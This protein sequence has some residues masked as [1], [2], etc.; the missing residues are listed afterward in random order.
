[1]FENLDRNSP[2][3]YWLLDY[4]EERIQDD[5]QWN[6]AWEIKKFGENIFKEEYIETIR[7][8]RVQEEDYAL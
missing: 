8:A 1:M 4:I 3:L 2:V 6:V 5:K 7:L